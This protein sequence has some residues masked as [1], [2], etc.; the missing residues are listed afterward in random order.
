[1]TRLP[2]IFLAL[3][4]LS[5]GCGDDGGTTDTGTSDGSMDTSPSDTGGGDTGGGDTGGDTGGCG[6]NTC[7]PCEPAC[8]PLD[9]CEGGSWIC[10]CICEGPAPSCQPEQDSVRSFIASNKTCVDD[11]DCVQVSNQ[12]YEAQEDCCVVYMASGYDETMW[13]TL[14]AALD[15]CVMPLGGCGCCAAI[16][17]DPA[18]NAGVCGPAMP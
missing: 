15:G 18:C 17:A 4:L 2:Q 10:E 7:G 13:G 5:F 6:P 14:T 1:M 8:S 12:C 16:P 9:R 3:A 11:G